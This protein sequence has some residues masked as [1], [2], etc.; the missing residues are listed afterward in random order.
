MEISDW[1]NI[2]DTPSYLLGSEIGT[3]QFDRLPTKVET[4]RHY[5]YQ[6]RIHRKDQRQSAI[7]TAKSIIVI[8]RNCGRDPQLQHR[9][10]NKIE[11]LVNEYKTLR[12]KKKRLSSKQKANFLVK[13]GQLF[14]ISKDVTKRNTATS[15]ISPDQI[16]SHVPFRSDNLIYADIQIAGSS[17]M[18]VP[19]VLAIADD[20]ELPCPEH[21]DNQVDG[22]NTPAI[23]AA[24][25]GN[26]ASNSSGYCLRQ[27]KGVNR[28]GTTNENLTTSVKFAPS[29][30]WRMNVQTSAMKQRHYFFL[31]T[32]RLS[33]SIYRT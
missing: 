1:W 23:S 24:V 6:F 28:I 25:S 13:N 8:W 10:A 21:A 12:R 30:A 4:L 31:R 27:K 7:A 3:L 2:L 22:S 14:D 32:R 29:F 15:I 17:S 9:A 33:T 20:N 16:A 18:N 26:D 19:V 5:F 11:K